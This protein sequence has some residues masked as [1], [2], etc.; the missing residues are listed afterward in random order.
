GLPSAAP[1]TIAWDVWIGGAAIVS[2]GLSAGAGS[3][4]G[5]GSVVTRSVPKG[6]LP[7]GNPCRAIRALVHCA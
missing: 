6:V 5:A 1:A 4:I 2:P 7:A 3:V